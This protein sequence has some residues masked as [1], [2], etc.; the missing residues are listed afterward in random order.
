MDTILPEYVQKFAIPIEIHGKDTDLFNLYI[1]RALHFSKIDEHAK[2]YEKYFFKT[3]EEAIGN[4]H[5]EKVDRK[6][7]EALA[8]DMRKQKLL[9]K[10]QQ[11]TYITPIQKVSEKLEIS[12]IHAKLE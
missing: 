5:H 4:S 10:Y 3:I 8:E 2:Q 7:K 12:P 9:E 11:K 1:D 6:T